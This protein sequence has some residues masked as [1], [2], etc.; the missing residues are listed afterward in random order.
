MNAKLQIK[1]DLSD[2]LFYIVIGGISIFSYISQQKAKKQAEEIE[3]KGTLQPDDVQDKSVYGDLSEDEDDENEVLQTEVVIENP[4]LDDIF[5]ALREKRPLTPIQPR[6]VKV[7]PQTPQPVAAKPA[8]VE[9]NINELIEKEGR[10]STT[11]DVTRTAISD[12]E[13][14]DNDTAV[15]LTD[16]DW[17]KAVIAAEILNRKY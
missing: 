3:R 11:D 1:M 15:D 4:T 10:R 2:I 12:K 17:R 8:A 13:V 7:E 16:I 5:R 14:Y 9:V 6:M